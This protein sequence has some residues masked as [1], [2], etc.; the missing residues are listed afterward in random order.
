[1]TLC[2]SRLGFNHQTVVFG[3]KPERCQ[4]DRSQQIYVT[5]SS[6]QHGFWA[7]NIESLSNPN[8]EPC[9]DRSDRTETYPASAH[10]AG[11]AA[12]PAGQRSRPS[13]FWVA[14]PPAGRMSSAESPRVL[15]ISQ[16]RSRTRYS[17]VPA[18]QTVRACRC[19]CDVLLQVSPQSCVFASSLVLS[20]GR[21]V[22]SCGRRPWS[23]LIFFH[24]GRDV[25]KVNTQKMSALCARHPCAGTMLL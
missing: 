21:V 8:T 15:S 16:A 9:R 2:L 17:S 25:S 5:T 12:S 14:A 22:L 7:L 20:F 3:S 24:L 11:G 18:K 10:P 13:P 6:V 23:L 1:M 4:A 19:G